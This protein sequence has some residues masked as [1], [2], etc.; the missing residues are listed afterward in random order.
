MNDNQIVL[1]VFRRNGNP[2]DLE[3]PPQQFFGIKFFRIVCQT[4]N[5]M[6]FIKSRFDN[7]DRSMFIYPTKWR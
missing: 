4:D 3:G 2:D 6:I 7:K 5:A 1:S